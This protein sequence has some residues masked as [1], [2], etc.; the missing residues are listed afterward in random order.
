M[1]PLRCLAALPRETRRC[2]A[3][4]VEVPTA[5]AEPYEVLGPGAVL[6][7]DPVS[8]VRL[9]RVGVVVG[10]LFER[11]SG[12]RVT[13]I[14]PTRLAGSP[15][16]MG[17]ML[18]NDFW[19]AW[20]ALLSDPATGEWF[21]L[22][23]PTGLLPLYRI[24]HQDR[25]VFVTDLALFIDSGLPSPRVSWGGLCAHLRWN[26]VRQVQTALNGVAEV[27]PGCLFSVPV[28]RP[29]ATLWDPWAYVDAAADVSFEDAA[30]LL[31]ANLIKTVGSWASEA[32]PVA[33]AASGGVDS[34]VVAAA[35]AA[36]G[37]RFACVT[38]ATADPSGDE[39]RWVRGLADGL[40]VD[41]R[42]F[43][44]E[45]ARVD[46]SASASAGLP[47]PSRKAFLHEIRRGFGEATGALRTAIVFDGNAGDNVF[48]YLHS[49]APVRDRLRYDGLGAGALQTLF[50]MCRITDCAAAT[51]AAAALRNWRGEARAYRWPANDLLLNPEV[52]T[53]EAPRPVVSW[54]D[55]PHRLKAGKT[56]HLTLIMAS[57]NTI[58]EFGEP[59]APFLFSP[60]L[61]QPIVE[62]CLAI[63][64]WHWCHGGINR[65][66]AR[67]AFADRLPKAIVTRISKS[68]PD[69]LTL[70]V[71]ER[72]RGLIRDMLLGGLLAEQRLID[73]AAVETALACDT[74]AEDTPAYRLLDLVEA[75]AW[76][77]SWETG[78]GR[79]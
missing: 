44:Y 71:F 74:Y 31:R 58:K 75:E 55:E 49:S 35:L 13:G 33:L 9:G 78:A 26:N 42:D 70:A 12:R 76:A 52:L 1:K 57:L 67:Q 19:G 40:G 21:V 68:G 45:P 16:D 28:D 2:P 14:D 5:V 50:D 32:G 4:S 41:L 61:S 18:I 3:P 69:S 73:R 56:A 79:A 20:F 10:T 54:L 53:C 47:R 24:E 25:S 6:W 62:C 46:L 48:C 65:A 63:P 23:D 7:C 30:R 11:S 37:H 22:R 43:V 17:A 60:L 29:V 59:A 8:V 66:V 64:T 27:P 77:R 51:M 36:G 15:R 72:S 39:R 38:A 34:S